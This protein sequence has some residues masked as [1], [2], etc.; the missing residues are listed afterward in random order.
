MFSTK[1]KY[2]LVLKTNFSG[3]S[4]QLPDPCICINKTKQTFSILFSLNTQ[5]V[6]AWRYKLRGRA[7][8]SHAVIQVFDLLNHFGRTMALGSTQSLTEINTSII[9]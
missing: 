8:D 4:E 9:A 1:K 2:N 5:V 6:D 3:K 7:L